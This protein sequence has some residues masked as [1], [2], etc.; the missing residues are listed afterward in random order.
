MTEPQPTVQNLPAQ[1]RAASAARLGNLSAIIGRIVEAVDQET[2]A[3]RRGG[4]DFDIKA[5]NMRKSRYLY[6]LTR[7]TKGIEDAEVLAEHR[8]S[9]VHLRERLAANESV[10]LAHMN[11]VGE[12]AALMQSVIQRAETDGTY[13]EG[14]FGWAR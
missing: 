8:D 12:V 14:E 13:T 4:A 3:I 11:A 7:A 2:A 5:A 10:I 9:L 6:E 1:T